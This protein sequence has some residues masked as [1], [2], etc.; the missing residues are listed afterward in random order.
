MTYNKIAKR[1]IKINVHRFLSYREVAFFVGVIFMPH[2]P[3]R[4]CRYSGCS[5]LTVDSSG[6]CNV[7]KPLVIRQRNNF[8][9]KF[10]R[11]Y[12]NSERY[13]Y[14]WRKLR[15]CFLASNPLCEMCKQEG[16]FTEATEVHHVKPLA[17]GGTNNFEN[18]MPLCKPCHSKITLTSANKK[19]RAGGS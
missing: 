5:N 14:Q 3:K 7:H 9:N 16:K 11:P 8:F 10:C 13:G 1:L 17:D 6:Y 15:N 2:K 12:K 18:L 19:R 4:P